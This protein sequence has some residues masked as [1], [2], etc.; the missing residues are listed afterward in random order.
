MRHIFYFICMS[1]CLQS[2]QV[3]HLFAVPVE[4]IKGNK[5]PGP[6]VMDSPGLPCGQ[7]PLNPRL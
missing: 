5:S 6:R 2:I 1:I 4:S 7:E 3:Y